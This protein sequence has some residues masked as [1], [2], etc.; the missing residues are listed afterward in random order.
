MKNNI[1]LVFLALNSSYE[2]NRTFS[3][4]DKLVFNNEKVSFS[5]YKYLSN[6]LLKRDEKLL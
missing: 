1:S 3:D 5:D 2:R 4:W 6:L